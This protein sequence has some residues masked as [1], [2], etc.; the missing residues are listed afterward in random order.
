MNFNKQSKIEKKSKTNLFRRQHLINLCFCFVC[1]MKKKTMF[2][3][4]RTNKGITTRRIQ[5]NEEKKGTTTIYAKSILTEECNRRKHINTFIMCVRVSWLHDMPQ[6][7]DIIHKKHTKPYT[8]P[9][10]PANTIH[11]FSNRCW[12]IRS[13]RW[14]IVA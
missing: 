14:F 3:K 10:R 1:Q 13:F 12:L 9:N 5:R 7:I 6:Q 2:F 11:L 8:Q 4:P